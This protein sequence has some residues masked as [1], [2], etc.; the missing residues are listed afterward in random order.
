[1]S[2]RAWHG[3]GRELLR[4]R[5]G[6][7][8]ARLR[9]LAQ[10]P[11]RLDRLGVLN[12]W[13]LAAAP[14]RT[15]L[16]GVRWVEPERAATPGH[17]E[18]SRGAGTPGHPE[19]SR[20]AGTPG[21]PERSRGAGTPGHP[22][23]S[24]GAPAISPIGR[25]ATSVGVNGGSALLEAVDAIAARAVAPALA[26]GGGVDAAVVLAAWRET[27]RPLPAVLTLRTGLPGYDELEAAQAIASALGVR[28]E[29]V[30]VPTT[31]WGELLEPGIQAVETPLYNLHPLS[32]LALAE[33]AR[34]RGF[35]TLVTGDGA[36]AVCAGRADLDYVP[37]VAR[38]TEDAGVALESPFLED[39]VLEALLR[40]GADPK[41]RALREQACAL[42]VPRELAQAPKR[43][44]WLPALPLTL[45]PERLAPL[46]AELSL[47]LVLETD[48]Q[49]VGWL[50]LELCARQLAGA[51]TRE[52]GGA[53][54]SGPPRQA[55][56][57]RVLAQGAS[58]QS[59][60]QE[61]PSP[62]RQARGERELVQLERIRDLGSMDPGEA[63]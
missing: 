62:P 52:A 34:A 33:A 45:A 11:L 19:R 18:R 32:R 35:R 36:D 8:A 43:P 9:E 5:D 30:D 27:G 51:A 26:L 23:R 49:R 7:R 12:A 25:L 22:E 14:A 40:A 47:P 48:A 10:V 59:R 61:D 4:Q 37:L 56:G 15:V 44:R 46:A 21:H 20:G 57:E 38:L 2:A 13:G 41:K 42:G 24:R 50:T 16:E 29:L 6:A 1:M 58:R 60:V 54:D 63:R 17:P 53:Q 39:G 55:R 28:C 3:L 31:R